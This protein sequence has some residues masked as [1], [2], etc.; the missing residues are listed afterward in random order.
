MIL[1]LYPRLAWEPI[2][3]RIQ[4]L[5][6]FT[7]QSRWWKRLLVGYAEEVEP[8]FKERRHCHL[9]GRV[10]RRRCRPARLGSGPR[11]NQ[12]GEPRQVRSLEIEPRGGHEIQ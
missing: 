4:S 8:A 10:E 2:R 6:D 9:V 7:E 1:L 5:G 12:R 3:G 11:Q